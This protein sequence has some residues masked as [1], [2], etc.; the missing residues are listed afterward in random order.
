M[1]FW[2]PHPRY[3]G[4]GLCAGSE[5][6]TMQAPGFFSPGRVEQAG[7][8]K[9]LRLDTALYA[10]N[11]PGKPGDGDLYAY[12]LNTGASERAFIG[13]FRSWD[14][15]NG[16]VVTNSAADAPFYNAR[17]S[18][19]GRLARGVDLGRSTRLEVQVA[20]QWTAIDDGGLFDW[21]WSQDP[22]FPDA[23][24]WTAVVDGR[25]VT[26]LWQDGRRLDDAVVVSD[27]EGEPVLVYAADGSLLLLT[28]TDEMPPR[29]FVRPP[30]SRRGWH[31][32]TGITDHPDAAPVDAT[33][34]R[35]L[36]SAEGALGERLVDLTAPT[37]DLR[38]TPPIP[39]EPPMQTPGVSFTNFEAG[40]E[41]ILRTGQPV[42]IETYDRNDTTAARVSLRLELKAPGVIGVRV[43]MTNAV[44]SDLSGDSRR[45][46][47]QP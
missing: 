38:L 14:C 41:K 30:A 12:R 46:K 9:W 5:I 8:P 27:S 22:R 43:G 36:W 32:H 13:P 40:T 44:G 35:V 42:V 28:H 15:C 3:D 17:V 7:G 29:A 2:F 1:D 25:H 33:H 19:S 31:V 23:L 20:G 21:R 45:V 24:A 37:V 39:P 16:H 6:A 47:V 18:P 10:Q 11:T 4:T 26:R 34:L